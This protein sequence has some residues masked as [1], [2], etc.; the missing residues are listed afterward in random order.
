MNNILLVIIIIMLKSPDLFAQQLEMN[1]FGEIDHI[2]YLKKGEERK[3]N[4]RNQAILQTDLTANVGDNAAFCSSIE[5]RDDQSDPS[6]NRVYLDEAY[7]DYTV[8]D[9]DFRIGKQII[10]W[11]KADAINPTDNITP[12]DF[13]DILDTDDER[14]GLVSLKADYYFGDWS[15]EGVL[16]PTFTVSL[17]PTQNSRWYPEMPGTIPNPYYPALGSPFLR[18]TYAVLDPIL[19]D[20]NFRSAQTAMKLSST[21]A[22]WDFSLIY[23][24][25]Y[26]DLPAYRQFQFL[27]GDSVLIQLQ[28]CYHRKKAIGGDF[29]SAFGSWGVRG[30]AAYF[31]TADPN[32][33]NPEID[34]PYFQYVIGI[35]RTFSNLIGENNLFVLIQWIQ[36]ISRYKSIYRSDDL[37][38]IFQKSIS[39]RLEYELGSFSKISLEGV[40]NFKKKDYYLHPSFSYQLSD[41]V[42]LKVTGDFLSGKTD[43]FFGSYR[44]NK[45]VQ[46]KVK[47][48]F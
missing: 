47:Y 25:G 39:G 22:G 42:E 5:F 7:I 32:G 41:G 29:A 46:V 30:E 20:E 23:Y 36:E 28:P 16:V 12:W 17:L 40:Y 19:P 6:R 3:I 18:A 31:F 48:S 14:I 15:L 37:N 43:S 2:S 35:D 27:Q 33:T 9:F 24:Y 13:S 34:D 11:G 8:G 26:D 10:I 38:H 21:M 4:S 45:R 1:G 44:N